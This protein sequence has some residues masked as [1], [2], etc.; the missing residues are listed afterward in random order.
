MITAG[1]S[2]ATNSFISQF[3]LEGAASGPLAGLTLAVK[4]LY[5]VSICS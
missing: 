1:Q 3:R 4:D 5:D 2:D